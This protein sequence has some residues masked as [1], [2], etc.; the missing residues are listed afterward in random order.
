MKFI[1]LFSGIGGFD[2][3]LERAG[4]ECVG[5]VEI[6][7]FYQKILARHWPNVKRIGDIRD[8]KGTEFEPAELIC[9]GYPCQCDSSAGNMRGQDDDRWLWPEM[10]RIIEFNRPTWVIGENVINHENMGLKLVISDLESVGYKVRPFIIPNAACG[11]PTVE[12]HIWT[13][14]AAP[15]VGSKW[16][17]TVAYPYN[18][19]AWEF[20]GTDTGKCK[21]WD[22]PESRV[23]RVRQGVPDQLDRIKSL[24]NA[25]SPQIVEIIGRAI[26][27]VERDL[28][29]AY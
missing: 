1:S 22:L 3:G 28:T 7:R 10:F 16:C 13:I 2:L 6:D 29:N 24:G 19:T 20:Q 21:R 4:M 18:G 8:V 25:V 23:C 14:A 12:R 15:C 11:L 9:G 17:K 5:Q 26:M 27:N